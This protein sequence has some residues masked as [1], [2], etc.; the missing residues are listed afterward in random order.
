MYECEIIDEQMSDPS[1][2]VVSSV[3]KSKCISHTFEF[4]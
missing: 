1:E 2:Q 4:T 3:L